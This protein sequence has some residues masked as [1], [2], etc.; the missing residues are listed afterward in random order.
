M[1]DNFYIKMQFRFQRKKPKANLVYSFELYSNTVFFLFAE[2][3]F[4]CRLIHRSDE[5]AKDFA[6][7]FHPNLLRELCVAF[8]N[9]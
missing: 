5:M 1:S 8:T 9:R 4:C 2:G 7:R 3:F 6:N